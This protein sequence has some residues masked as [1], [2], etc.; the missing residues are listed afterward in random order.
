MRDKLRELSPK[1]ADVDDYITPQDR[2]SGAVI[3]RAG[4]RY[5]LW[6]L[7]TLSDETSFLAWED[8]WFANDPYF[9]PAV[10]DPATDTNA[11]GASWAEI[12]RD[13]RTFT[14]VPTTV[15]R[16]LFGKMRNQ[17]MILVK[18]NPCMRALETEEQHPKIHL[19]K[20]PE[21][22]S[23]PATPARVRRYAQRISFIKLKIKL[24]TSTARGADTLVVEISEIVDRRLPR[25]GDGED[26]T[27]NMVSSNMLWDKTIQYRLFLRAEDLGEDF[28]P[29]LLT[30]GL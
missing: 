1:V 27:I 11:N 15:Q 10:Y 26:E 7:S 5:P 23:T 14:T 16:K 20:E 30:S 25:I 6:T 21:T 8:E 13:G 3:V 4:E 29:R 24:L 17:Q 9:K 19:W 18:K 22:E 28:L 12:T 2:A